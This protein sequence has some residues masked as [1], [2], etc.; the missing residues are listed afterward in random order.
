MVG[1]GNGKI[2]PPQAKQGAKKGQPYLHNALSLSEWLMTTGWQ[3]RCWKR[4][5]EK[6]LSA[7]RTIVRFQTFVSARNGKRINSNF[8]LSCERALCKCILLQARDGSFKQSFHATF[9]PY[10]ELVKGFVSTRICQRYS[11]A[12]PKQKGFF[13]NLISSLQ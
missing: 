9:A 13:V 2:A 11:S 4:S 8:C 12:C 3:A 5:P 10:L 1:L 6:T 7:K